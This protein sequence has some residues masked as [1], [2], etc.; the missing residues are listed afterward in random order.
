MIGGG[1]GKGPSPI[2]EQP[3]GFFV[4]GGGGG[5]G[6]YTDTY[7]IGGGAGEMNPVLQ[8]FETISTGGAGAAGTPMNK[9][10]RCGELWEMYRMID[11]KCTITEEMLSL[12][13]I[14]EEVQKLREVI[15]KL[16]ETGKG[17]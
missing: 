17:I 2:D 16:I 12:K 1:G 9:C 4:I 10:D 15:E 8:R 5:K 7:S 11:H 13:A 3:E 6:P 14:K